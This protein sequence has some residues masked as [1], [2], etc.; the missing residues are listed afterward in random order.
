MT[1]TRRLPPKPATNPFRSPLSDGDSVA[2]EMYLYPEV[3]EH[4]EDQAVL[5]PLTRN[6][7]AS[8]YGGPASQPAR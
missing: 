5:R 6:W 1:A 8:P 4:T 3:R 7:S 2:E